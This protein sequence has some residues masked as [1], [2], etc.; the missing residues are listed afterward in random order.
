MIELQAALQ[1]PK[2]RHG[3]NADEQRGGNKAVGKVAERR[4]PFECGVEL[5][6]NPIAKT[7]NRRINVD[8]IAQNAANND[9]EHGNGDAL[10]F[11]HALHAHEHHA[12]AQALHKKIAQLLRYTTLEHQA[13]HA[14]DNCGNAVHQRTQNDHRRPFSHNDATRLRRHAASINSSGGFSLI[15]RHFQPS[16]SFFLHRPH[17]KWRRLRGRVCEATAKDQSPNRPP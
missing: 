8:P 12:Q 1:R 7:V 13:K 3:S 17:Q 10:P 15:R 16:G 6:L 4:R 2:N 14:A 9:R 11:H 5:A